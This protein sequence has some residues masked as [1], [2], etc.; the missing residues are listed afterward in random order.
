MKILIDI[1]HPAHVH[2]FRNFIS[3]M[4][5]NG[6][7]FCIVARNKECTTELLDNYKISYYSRGKGFKGLIGK[8][9]YMFWADMIVLCKTLK[10]NP[11]IFL[12]FTSPYTAQIAWLLNKA[13]ISF[14]DTEHAKLGILSFLPF[15]KTILTPNCFIKDLGPK[16]LRFNGYMELCYLNPFYFKPD[17]SIYDL[18]KIPETQKYVIIRFVSWDASHDFGQNGF[19]YNQKIK[20]VEELSRYAE[21]FISSESKLPLDLEKYQLNIPPDKLHDILAFSSLYIGEGGTTANECACLGVPNILV[22]SLLNPKTIPGIHRE[23]EEYGLQILFE[24]ANDKIIETACGIL[25]DITY[26]EEFRKKMSD[27]INEKIDVTAFM[28]WF[29][30]N[31]PESVNIMKE[32]PEYQMRFK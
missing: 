5:I 21:V 3:L 16:Q 10:F 7:E 17:K 26:K 29:I 14:S 32:N 12:S 2:Y 20:I 24:E 15:T 4:K 25:K 6:H 19:S 27:M 23:L 30:E 1:G 22:N 11:N 13:H 8:F 9:I 18:L 31:Y 28:V